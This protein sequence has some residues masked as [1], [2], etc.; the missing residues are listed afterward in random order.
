MS[1]LARAA[2]PEEL[3]DARGIYVCKVCN[4]CRE[5]KEG[6]YRPEIFTNSNYDCDEQI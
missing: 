1:E 4:G 3:Y 6:Q 2:H 5:E